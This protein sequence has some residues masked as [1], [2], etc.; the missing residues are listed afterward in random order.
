MLLSETT[1]PRKLQDVIGQDH[2]IST[3]T[4]YKEDPWNIPHMIFSGPPGCGKTSA[5]YAYALEVYGKD[6]D[7]SVRF[8]N[9]SGERS[10]HTIIKKVH[11][12]CKYYHERKGTKG[13]FVCDE[14]D[15]MTSEAQDIMV[16]CV[17]LYEKR[18]N[19]VFIMNRL[20]DISPMLTD[21]CE[22]HQFLPIQD[23]EN[24][25]RKVLPDTVTK[26]TILK[27]KN[28]YSGDL[29]RILNATQ[30]IVLKY[31]DFEPEWSV[32]SIENDR[33]SI[34]RNIKQSILTNI[35]DMPVS[36]IE[37]LMEIAIGLHRPGSIRA[38]S[39]AYKLAINKHPNFF[40]F[41]QDEHDSSS[42]SQA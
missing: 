9:L 40:L 15:C 18:W 29:R 31:D 12:V 17:K 21:L 26:D 1:R 3:L 32:S 39:R 7:R 25:L 22:I 19:F 6:F 30:G 27:I 14:A 11:S 13:L 8:M 16:H 20:S 2:I 33:L 28:Y 34:L 10:V 42:G 41:S 37:N 36:F 24:L 38:Y 5:I 4:K 35:Q 23:P